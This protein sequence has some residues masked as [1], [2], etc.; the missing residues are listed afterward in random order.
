MKLL[1]AEDVSQILNISKA[2][3]FL[4]MRRGDLPVVRMGRLVR[5]SEEDLDRFV[6][7][8]TTRKTTH[9]PVE[10]KAGL[11]NQHSLRM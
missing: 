4:I 9:L 2:Q 11:T 7:E 10:R 3:A 6:A 1:T 8:K 5:V